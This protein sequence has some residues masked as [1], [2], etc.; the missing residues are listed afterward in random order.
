MA[1]LQGRSDSAMPRLL[2]SCLDARI[3]VC[4]S[5]LSPYLIPFC[6]LYRTGCAACHRH[7][8]WSDCSFS[9]SWSSFPVEPFCNVSDSFYTLVLLLGLGQKTSALVLS[10]RPSEAIDSSFW[11]AR[12]S[13]I[14]SVGDAS[15]SLVADSGFEYRVDLM[16]LLWG[17]C[18]SSVKAAAAC[19]LAGACVDNFA[20]SKGR[21]NLRHSSTF[22]W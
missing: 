20:C 13:T 19:G 16:N 5:H 11:T 15:N 1:D 10:A 2:M 9:C 21:G 3:C 12:Y 14:F 18:P 4:P 8:V 22:T 6:R 7:S 17:S